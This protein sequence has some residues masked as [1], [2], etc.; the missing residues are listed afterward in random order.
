MSAREFILL[1]NDNDGL[2]A[3]ADERLVQL[4]AY[5]RSKRCT[6][7]VPAR[8]SIDPLDIPRLLTNVFILEVDGGEFRFG[9]VGEALN[10]RYGGQLKGQ[11]LSQLLSGQ[12]LGETTEEHMSSVRKRV[13]VYTRNTEQSRL[14]YDDFQVYQRLLLPLA[15]AQDTIDAILGAMVFESP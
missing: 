14:V 9:L 12:A 2:P 3:S 5:W 6:R 7:D 10:A 1:S 11:T 8:S 15:D 4:L 13:P